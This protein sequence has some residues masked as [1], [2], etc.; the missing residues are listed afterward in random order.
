MVDK[1]VNV[2]TELSSANV[3]DI[4]KLKKLTGTQPMRVQQKGQPA[5]DIELFAK[6]IFNTNEM[7]NIPDNTDARY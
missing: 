6:Q 1:T 2:D 5:F 4:S 3:K 7:S